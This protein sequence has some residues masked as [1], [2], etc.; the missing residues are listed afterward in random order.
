M[1]DKLL[2]IAVAMTFR[3]GVVQVIKITIVFLILCRVGGNIREIFS[4]RRLSLRQRRYYTAR[5]WQARPGPLMTL[6]IV[7]NIV[8]VFFGALTMTCLE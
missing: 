7:E 6:L 4:V 3:E 2:A 5:V 1:S 8:V